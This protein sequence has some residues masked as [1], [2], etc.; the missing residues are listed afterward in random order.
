ME[1]CRYFKGYK[2]CKYYWVD[3]SWDCTTCSHNDPFQ[4]RILLIKLDALGDVVRSTALIEGIKKKY[5][6]AQL[7]WLTRESGSF[8][9][10]TNPAVDRVLLYNEEVIR[11]LLC[12]KFD[13]LIN[14]DKDEKISA[15]AN[16]ISAQEKRGYGLHTEGYVIPF[17]KGA[18]YHYTICLD[19][20]GSKTKNTK[21]Y[22]QL[23][24]EIAELPYQGEKPI[25]YL[26]SVKASLFRQKF[27]QDNNIQ[28]GDFVIIANT[29][30]GP[31]YPHKQW[32]YHGFR[33]VLQKLVL[34][35]KV[36]VILTGADSE[37]ERNSSLL[38]DVPSSQIIDTTNKYSVE[39]FCYLV[40]CADLVITGDTVGIH[41]AIA[42]NKNIVSFFG[43]TPHQEVDLFGLGKKFVRQE[44]DCLNCYDQFPCP[45]SGRCMELITAEDVYKEVEALRR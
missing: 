29:G 13:I 44:L 21:S 42:L 28:D 26:D 34:D 19:N 39:D 43:P 8:F 30:C 22:Q 7:T 5:P 10:M 17:N 27:F 35:P 38:K 2:P 3:R 36:K 25:L 12:E 15:L 23:I 45:Y 33:D 40:N 11:R 16:M 18:K 9:V 24:Y 4:E 41:I 32:T 1:A 6:G 14:L 31:V 37:L 20:Y